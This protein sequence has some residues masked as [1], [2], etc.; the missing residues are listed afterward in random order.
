MKGK[1]KLKIKQCGGENGYLWEAHKQIKNE[2]TEKDMFVQRQFENQIYYSFDV[3]L[4]DI[5]IFY[6]F[7][8]RTVTNFFFRHFIRFNMAFYGIMATIKCF[9]VL[10]C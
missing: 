5:H 2:T 1:K 7:C 8:F 10:L 6:G 9:H 3:H 4:F